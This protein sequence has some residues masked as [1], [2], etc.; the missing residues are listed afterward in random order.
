MSTPRFV[1]NLTRLAELYSLYTKLGSVYYPMK[2]NDHFAVVDHLAKLGSSF[3]I[4][5]IAHLRMLLGR[6]VPASRVLFS[7]PVD[8]HAN[9]EKAVALGV[10]FFTVDSI[11]EF[12]VI[13]ELSPHSRFLLR[14]SISDALGSRSRPLEKWG[15]NLAELPTIVRE[16]REACVGASLY[17]PSEVYGLDSLT[18]CVKAITGRLPATTFK[19]L[20]IGG[21]LDT[22]GSDKLREAVETY[23]R[24]TGVSKIIVEPGRNLVGPSM[25]L[26][27]TVTARR[28]RFGR[29]WLYVDCGIYSGLLDCVLKDRVFEVSLVGQEQEAAT[30]AFVLAGPTSD[31]SDIL[32]TCELPDSIVAG[33]VLCVADSGA[34]T[35]SVR[36]C[37]YRS[38]APTVKVVKG[39]D[40][41]DNH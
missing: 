37:F 32:G 8:T 16:M 3:E 5:S 22:P 39:A 13:R 9:R 31:S 10:R 15:C 12:R 34:Y 41:V 20:D 2:A 25:K 35:Y 36:T 26:Y 14:V 24:E 11:E 30:Q 6:G 21:G 1:L 17:L 33:D 7:L 27:V 4:D 38:R 28:S 19:I 40:E 23:R 18:R 29:D